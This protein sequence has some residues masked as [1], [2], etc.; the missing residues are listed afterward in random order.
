VIASTLATSPVLKSTITSVKESPE[1]VS[2]F[3]AY[4][5]GPPCL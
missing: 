2:D 3:H 5:T 4:H 1:T